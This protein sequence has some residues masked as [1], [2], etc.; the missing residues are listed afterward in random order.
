[1]LCWA[2]G[3]S[4]AKKLDLDVKLF[5]YEYIKKCYILS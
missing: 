5:I 4:S 1:M 2:I 3:V